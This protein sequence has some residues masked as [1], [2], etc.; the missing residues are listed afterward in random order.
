[1]AQGSHFFQFATGPKSGR[2]NMIDSKRHSAIFE[3]AAF[4]FPVHIIGCGGMGSRIAEG[5]VRMGVGVKGQSPIIL[6]DADKFEPHNVAN[7][8]IDNNDVGGFK[9]E[10]ITHRVRQVN[11]ECAVTARVM[12]VDS[13]IQLSGMVFICVDS[14]EARRSIMEE[15]IEKNRNVVCV[16]ETRMDAETAISH[17]FHPHDEHQSDCWWLYWHSD[18]EADH[19]GGCNQP[20][21]I[22]SAIYAT[23]TLA[24]KQFEQFARVGD[25]FEMANRLYLDLATFSASVETW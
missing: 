15:V 12:R 24:L 3:P 11:P 2:N 8:W 25:T 20:Q 19:V 14:M 22:I 1:M 13:F 23:T 16:I 7:Q 17:C 4:R 9:A 18:G 6:Y 5:I 10:R 21:S